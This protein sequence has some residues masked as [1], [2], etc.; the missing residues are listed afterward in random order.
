MAMTLYDKLKP[1][2]KAKLDKESEKYQMGD[3]IISN[4][5]ILIVYYY[6]KIGNSFGI[7]HKRYKI[8][9]RYFCG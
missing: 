2:I 5:F 9:N 7:D 3:L 6:I 4:N 1:E 8:Q